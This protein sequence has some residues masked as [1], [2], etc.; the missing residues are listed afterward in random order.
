MA[1]AQRT[2]ERPISAVASA[3][4]AARLE[5]A[6]AEDEAA[7][8]IAT[9]VARAAEAAAVEA[10]TAEALAE[11]SEALAAAANANGTRPLN[12]KKKAR[13]TATD[14][15]IIAKNK[16]FAA[17]TAEAKS[18]AATAKH[19]AASAEIDAVRAS[20]TDGA[21]AAQARASDAFAA[22]AAAEAAAQK[23]A[24]AEGRHLAFNAVKHEQIQQA[25]ISL[26]SQFDPDS[27]AGKATFASIHAALDLA[28][29][30][31]GDHKA[32]AQAQA[33]IITSLT[34][35]LRAGAV[36]AASLLA[37]P[38]EDQAVVW[39]MF[40]NVSAAITAFGNVRAAAN[41]L[42]VL[43]G[44]ANAD[45]SGAAQTL[46]KKSTE[47]LQDT[48]GVAIIDVISL[49]QKATTSEGV[50]PSGTPPGTPGYEKSLSPQTYVWIALIMAGFA[51][52]IALIVWYNPFSIYKAGRTLV[53][54][55]SL[56]SKALDMYKSTPVCAG[57][58]LRDSAGPGYALLTGAGKKSVVTLIIEI[59][60]DCVK[61]IISLLMEI[62]GGPLGR[63]FGTGVNALIDSYRSRLEDPS[64]VA[65]L[66][67]QLS[68]AV[69][70]LA[71]G[72]ASGGARRSSLY[73]KRKSSQ[74]RKITQKRKRYGRFRI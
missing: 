73:K 60:L 54:S 20:G 68:R 50:R 31:V 48:T 34:A 35:G 46:L 9:A 22:A 36:A 40:D 59:V 24:E 43:L 62:Y 33:T 52:I 61:L 2:A 69:M 47:N 26:L 14:N 42:E 74:K 51:S 56:I 65:G 64:A 58:F 72:G 16:R 32:L 18:A 71:S 19:T 21:L 7:A 25:A 5:Q 67:T 13:D 53:E 15:R 44:G 57:R 39:R 55:K 6:I 8:S 17:K 1:T 38:V 70:Q 66:L 4:K 63:I 3:A 45:K 37:V 29:A 49:A 23:A 30:A 11:R 27:A 10:D 28:A 41:N 12:A